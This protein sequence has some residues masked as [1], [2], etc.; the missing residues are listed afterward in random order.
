ME[1]KLFDKPVVCIDVDDTLVDYNLALRNWH[2]ETYGTSLKF[3]DFKSYFFNEVWG[4][5]MQEVIDKVEVFNKSGIP[6][7]LSPMEDAVDAVSLLSRNGKKLFVVTSRPDYLKEDTEY[8]VNNLFPNKFSDILFS[9]NHYSKRENSGKTKAEICKE[10][11]GFL[12]DDSL[13]YILQCQEEG[14]DAILFGNCP[15]NQS[16]GHK[17][18]T[19]TENW[20]K[21]L[22]I[23]GVI[24]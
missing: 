7:K 19:R 15:W 4:G 11:N 22:D 8:L 20:R 14:V 1:N 24:Y 13:S 5:T 9:S 3:E 17:G 10:L 12:I 18:I 23:L 6:K 16:N 21:T 2:N